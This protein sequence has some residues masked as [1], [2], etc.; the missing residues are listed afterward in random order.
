M[1]KHSL[2]ALVFLAACNVSPAPQSTGGIPV[3]DAGAAGPSCE[4]AVAVVTS[5][6]KSTN[7]VVSSLDGVTQSQSFVSSGA[8]KPGLA[9]AISGDVDVPFT[10]PG[11]K[12]VVI[13]DRYGTNVITWMDLASAE[14]IAQLPVGTGFQ[15]NPHDY[16]DV[17]AHRAYVSRYGTNPSPGAQPMDEGG[18][19]LVLDTE[20]FAITGRIAMPEDD[21][22]LQA[23]PDA[24]TWLRGQVV[25][26]LGRWSA[27]FARTGD[28][29]FA[30]I[31][32]ATNRVVWT[33]DIPGL[34][35]CGRLAVS[36]SGEFAAVACSSKLDMSTHKFDPKGSDI[37]LYDTTVLPPKEIR[38]F[39][40]GKKLD[41]GLQPTITFA[42]D[43]RILALTYGGNGKE[44][45]TAFALNTTTGD[46]IPLAEAPKAYVLGGMH[47][48][49]GCG[50]VCLLG[51]AQRNRLRRWHVSTEGRFEPLDD[52]VLDTLIGLPPRSLGGL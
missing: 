36:P 8:A 37:V 26:S 40:L 43:D 7:I 16:V 1:V 19:L 11:S 39:E 9:L 45:D 41:A 50:D 46:V 29:R 32:P 51:D 23:C 18:D 28:G 10:A 25:V 31:S 49:P 52:M 35:A 47:C 6:Y 15:S 24:M 22:G 30:A 5:D 3:S 13:L 48:A 20:K 17:D 12:R 4:R 42:S 14:V 38:R 34:Q 33:L 44:G 2:F 21:P 27:D